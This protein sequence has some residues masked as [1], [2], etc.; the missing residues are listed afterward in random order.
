MYFN[1]PLVLNSSTTNEASFMPI[2]EI[3]NRSLE[4][5]VSFICG[6]IMGSNI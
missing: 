4:M 1:Q 6:F 5:H 3:T 2:G